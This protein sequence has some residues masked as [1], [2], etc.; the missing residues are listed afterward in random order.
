MI[1]SSEG[2]KTSV[3]ESLSQDKI[4]NKHKRMHPQ[5]CLE[6]YAPCYLENIS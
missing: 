1:I 5:G 3:N 2:G 4:E 6:V